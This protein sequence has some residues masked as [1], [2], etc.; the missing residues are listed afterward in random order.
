M[1]FNKKAKVAS[2]KTK[3]EWLDSWM[4]CLLIVIA[5]KKNKH[6]VSR[7]A[8][9]HV[10]FKVSPNS[11]LCSVNRKKLTAYTS[12]RFIY[13]HNYGKQKREQFSVL[14]GKRDR[15]REKYTKTEGI[16]RIFF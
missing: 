5:I 8:D 1:C 4:L 11:S 7:P 10:L 6:P 13:H 9:S 3:V 15:G 14:T 2:G 12:E 16:I